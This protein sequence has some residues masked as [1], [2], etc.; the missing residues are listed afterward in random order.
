VLV[1]ANLL[2][3][4]GDSSSRSLRGGDDGDGNTAAAFSCA[5]AL[6]AAATLAGDEA[7]AGTGLTLAA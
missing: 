3:P 2:T 6:G 1:L 7:L 4:D 5:A